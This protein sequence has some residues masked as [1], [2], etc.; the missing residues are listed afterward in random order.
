M[1]IVFGPICFCQVTET[2]EESLVF[3]EP[4][5][6]FF[7]LTLKA[8]GAALA[9]FVLCGIIFEICRRKV[10]KDV[11]TG[12]FAPSRSLEDYIVFSN[13]WTIMQVSY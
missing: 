8:G 5:S 3:F 1:I 6:P 12:K 2:E 9:G 11:K 13:A 7:S 10:R 4:E